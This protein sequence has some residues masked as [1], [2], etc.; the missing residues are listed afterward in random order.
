MKPR[1]R[2][3]CANLVEPPPQRIFIETLRN[4]QRRSLVERQEA[5]FALQNV[6]TEYLTDRLIEV[7]YREVDNRRI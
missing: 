5:G 7:V 1:R 2:P 3:C 4:L 6:V